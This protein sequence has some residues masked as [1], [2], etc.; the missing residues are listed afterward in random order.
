M[1]GTIK[2][3]YRIDEPLQLYDEEDI[4]KE[5]DDM[6]DEFGVIRIGNIELY[7]SYVL[8][9]CD[10]IAYRCGFDDFLNS[11]EYYETNFESIDDILQDEK[12]KNSFDVWREENEEPEKD[13]EEWLE[14]N[15]GEVMN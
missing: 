4:Q 7:P 12:I 5:Y 11:C 1:E 2:M 14:E 13:M 10:P 8:E 15:W 3:Y 6:L 9:T